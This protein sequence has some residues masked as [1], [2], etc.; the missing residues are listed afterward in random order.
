MRETERNAQTEERGREKRK[1]N[2]SNPH[3]WWYHRSS[4][5]TPLP[6]TGPLPKSE[7]KGE[8]R[9]NVALA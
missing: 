6:A 4:Y 2:D 7:E 8:K 5:S 9:E 3:V 1:N